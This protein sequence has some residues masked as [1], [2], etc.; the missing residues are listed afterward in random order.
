[1]THL[2]ELE[3]QYCELHKDVHGIKARWYRAESVEQAQADLDRLEAEGKEVWARE[4]AEQ[5]AAAVRFEKRVAATIALGAGDRATAL[6][7]IHEAEQSD[8]DPEY[9]CYLCGLKYGYFKQESK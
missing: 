1:M 4:A 2:E 8:G 9:L 6:R 5:V 3:Q 7:W